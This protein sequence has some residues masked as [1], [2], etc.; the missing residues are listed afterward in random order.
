MTNNT[1]M[2][3]KIASGAAVVAI[4][5]YK[6]VKSKRDKKQEVKKES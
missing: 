1:L 4:G 5:T 6:I 2:V 3:V